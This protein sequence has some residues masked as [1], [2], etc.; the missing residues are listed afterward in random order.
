MQI[1]VCEAGKN[2]VGPQVAKSL[3]STVSL[4]RGVEGRIGSYGKVFIYISA[5]NTIGN[6]WEV[7]IEKPQALIDILRVFL[8]AGWRVSRTRSKS[9]NIGGLSTSVVQVRDHGRFYQLKDIQM[10]INWPIWKMF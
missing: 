9:R 4:R 5:I 1:K 8:T 7:G 6:T 2:F 3:K 10:S